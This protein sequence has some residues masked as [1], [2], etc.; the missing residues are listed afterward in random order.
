M[1]RRVSSVLSSTVSMTS[2]ERLLTLDEVAIQLG[3]SVREVYRIMAEGEL[4]PPVKIGRASRI[5]E[6]E[7]AAYIETLKNRRKASYLAPAS[8]VA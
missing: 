1:P 4:P 2:L 5:P 7:V 6:S 3:I 8:A